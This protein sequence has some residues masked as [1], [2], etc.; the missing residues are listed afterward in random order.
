MDIIAF[1]LVLGILWFAMAFG[2]RDSR[3]NEPRN[4]YPVGTRHL[5]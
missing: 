2:G 4:W 3:P 1:A 5:T